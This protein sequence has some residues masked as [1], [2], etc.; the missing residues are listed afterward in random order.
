MPLLVLKKAFNPNEPRDRTGKW[1]LETNGSAALKLLTA[2]SRER[3]ITKR[4]F[5][6]IDEKKLDVKGMSLSVSDRWDEPYCIRAIIRLPTVRTL[7]GW[8]QFLQ[9]F[10]HEY[11]HARD[12]I[13]GND[14]PGEVKEQRARQTE[15]LGKVFNPNEPR[16]PKGGKGGGRWAKIRTIQGLIDDAQLDHELFRNHHVWGA[17]WAVTN[18]KRKPT[19][20]GYTVVRAG[21]GQ[22]KVLK[23]RREMGYG[24]WDADVLYNWMGRISPSLR[25]LQRDGDDWRWRIA[26][27]VGILAAK[28]FNP[29]ETRIPKGQKGGGRWTTNAKPVE[30]FRGMTSREYHDWHTKGR[31]PKGKHTGAGKMASWAAEIASQGKNDL[32]VSFVAPPGTLRRGDADGHWITLQD[33]PTHA[34]SVNIESGTLKPKEEIEAADAQENSAKAECIRILR[35]MKPG[36]RLISAGR[37][38]EIELLERK[39]RSYKVRPHYYQ[40]M[41]TEISQLK[42]QHQSALDQFMRMAEHRNILQKF[43]PDMAERMGWGREPASNGEWKEAM[44]TANALHDQLTKAQEEQASKDRVE[45]RAWREGVFPFMFQ[46]GAYIDQGEDQ[47]QIRLPFDEWFRQAARKEM[48]KSSDWFTAA[49]LVNHIEPPP[50]PKLVLL[51]G[52]DHWQQEPRIPKGKEGAGQWTKEGT[53]AATG[54]KPDGA[55]GKPGQESSG[56]QGASSQ[57]GPPGVVCQVKNSKDEVYAHAKE[58]FDEYKDELDRGKGLASQAGA[59]TVDLNTMSGEEERNAAV[60]NAINSS[61][62]KFIIGPIKTADRAEKKVNA[63]YGGDWSRIKDLVRGTYLTDSPESARQLLEKLRKQLD[64]VD[65]KDKFTKP[66]IAGYRDMNIVVKMPNGHLTELQINV[67]SMLKAKAQAHDLYAQEQVLERKHDSGQELSPEEKER[68]HRLIEQQK[69]I[70]E[71]AWEKANMKKSLRRPMLILRSA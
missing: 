54:A 13:D 28:A 66:T 42:R 56:S 24:P 62:D 14:D 3:T 17:E 38:P 7:G 45:V 59:E 53:A 1:T 9:S 16:I 44:A 10:L 47:P 43:G 65:V 46:H 61:G 71:P 63:D 18:T 58:A 49:N 68:L 4:L 48:A 20:D 40:P 32:V 50:R 19:D 57:T 5:E 8:Q 12:F 52:G 41:N 60:E 11:S 51:K 26:R 34:T 29:D 37:G 30:V 35:A 27:Q 15:R 22:Y 69:A 6:F 55:P 23:D 21:A 25:D 36:G 64:V 31:I 33:I 70:Y 67:R 39:G 2:D